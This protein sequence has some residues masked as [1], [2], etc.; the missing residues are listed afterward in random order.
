MISR[1]VGAISFSA[2]YFNLFVNVGN[3]AIINGTG[4]KECSVS[5]SFVSMFINSSAFP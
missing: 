4:L 3:P 1:I 5:I 2:P